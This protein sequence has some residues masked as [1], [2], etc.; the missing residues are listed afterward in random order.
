MSEKLSKYITTFDYFDKTLIGLSATSG[1]I[2][3]IS[4]TSLV[5]SLVIGM[6]KKLLNITRN[7]NKKHNKI[8]LLATVLKL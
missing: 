1:G 4:F 2:G 3:I 5:F 6:I 7:K 8:F